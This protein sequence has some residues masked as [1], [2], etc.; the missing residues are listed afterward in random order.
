VPERLL[1]E[2]ARNRDAD[3]VG[4]LYVRHRA[5]VSVYLARVVGN[6]HDAEDLAA[7][8]FLKVFESIERFRPQGVPFVAWVYR[9]AR[10]VAVDHFRAR[11][12]AQALSERLDSRPAGN[13]SAEDE[14]MAAIAHR[15]MLADV[16][17]LSPGQRDVLVLRFVHSLSTHDSARILGRSEGS[18]KALQ[19]RA[20]EALRRHLDGHGSTLVSP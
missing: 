2:R 20:I 11:A 4:D 14:A 19:H 17:E 16:H 13:A 15:R 8:T 12:R 3:A 5:A 10:N 1:V 9:I 18:V 6:D 7:E